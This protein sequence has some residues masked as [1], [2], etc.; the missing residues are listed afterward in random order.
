V[1]WCGA[2]APARRK[3][4]D[5]AGRVQMETGRATDGRA[6]P[7]RDLRVVGLNLA[8]FASPL[9]VEPRRGFGSILPK[10]YSYGPIGLLSIFLFLF[11]DSV[12]NFF[13]F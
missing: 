5:D 12:A 7:A 3:G 2:A 8:H 13:M 10:P 6:A 1:R 9:Q 4:N 11:L